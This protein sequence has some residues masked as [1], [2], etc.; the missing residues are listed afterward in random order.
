MPAQFQEAENGPGLKVSADGGFEFQDATTGVADLEVDDVGDGW[1]D[2]GGEALDFG[3]MT[4][5]AAEAQATRVS[6][7]LAP[8]ESQVQKYLKQRKL[9]VD[10]VIAGQF[11]E[12]LALLRNTMALRTDNAHLIAPYF[13]QQYM[14]SQC[15]V[16]GLP[17]T[18]S[19]LQPLQSASGPSEPRILYSLEALNQIKAL[20]HQQVGK[21]AFDDALITF[22]KILHCVVL[23]AAESRD[24]EK[25][26]RELIKIASNYCTALMFQLGKKQAEEAGD[27]GKAITLAALMTGIALEPNHKFLFLRQAMVLTFKQGNF[28]DAAGFA[29]RILQT[30]SGSTGQMVQQTAQQAKQVLASAERSGTNKHQTEFEITPTLANIGENGLRMC[31]STMTVI[32]DVQQFEKCSLCDAVYHT[33]LKGRACA[34]CQIGEVGKQVL[35]LKFRKDF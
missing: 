11:G 13:E 33:Q 20:G 23:C 7:K 31:A 14:A 32:R 8:G 18:S 17:Q 4:L 5:E 29:T 35:G 30:T 19:T 34:V 26:I 27:F 28:V 1:D 12:A 3:D 15:S 6:E 24:D 9:A 21:G 25:E 16:P 2:L 22:R 10:L